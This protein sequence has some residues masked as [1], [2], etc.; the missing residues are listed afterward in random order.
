MFIV[1]GKRCVKQ[2]MQDPV[3]VSICLKAAVLVTNLTICSP[4]NQNVMKAAGIIAA[5][6]EMLDCL[7]SCD[8]SGGYALLGQCTTSCACAHASTGCA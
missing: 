3:A 5:L 4:E 8:L 1:C 6:V 2:D 7:I